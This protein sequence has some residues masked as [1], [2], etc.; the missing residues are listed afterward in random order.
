[1]SEAGKLENARVVVQGSNGFE[2]SRKKRGALQIIFERHI[3]E[4]CCIGF[5]Q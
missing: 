5:V 2:F 3:E 4:M 1:M